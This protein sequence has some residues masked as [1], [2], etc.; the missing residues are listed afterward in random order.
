V[1]KHK[2]KGQGVVIGGENDK[3]L[4]KDERRQATAEAAE[5][6]QITYE[7]RGIGAAG[8]VDKIFYE[9]KQEELQKYQ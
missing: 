3:K 6:R 9:R 5:K 7:S 1:Q 4:S 8:E 2:I